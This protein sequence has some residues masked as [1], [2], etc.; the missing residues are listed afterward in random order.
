MTIAYFWSKHRKFPVGERTS[1][2]TALSAFVT[3]IAGLLLLLMVIGGI[4]VGIFTAT[5]SAAM[6]VLYFLVLAFIYR[7]LK[8]SD[9]TDI[10]DK[11]TSK[12]GI[13]MLQI[14][15]TVS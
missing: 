15:S 8:C 5:E 1:L 12:T 13:V 3:A 4:V 14:A 11:A 9:L 2:K 6:A 7:E 10:L